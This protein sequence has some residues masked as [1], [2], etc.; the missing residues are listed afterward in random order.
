[1]TQCAVP[2]CTAGCNSTVCQ[3]VC[4]THSNLN[5]TGENYRLFNT[6]GTAVDVLCLSEWERGRGEGQP[7]KEES[8]GA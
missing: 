7:L 1:M 6:I 4:H 8:R 3:S 2:C 5:I